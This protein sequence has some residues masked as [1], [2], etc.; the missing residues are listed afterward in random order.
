[1][2]IYN[3]KKRVQRNTL[4]TL[5]YQLQQPSIS[6]TSVK[7]DPQL[8]AWSHPPPLHLL[9]SPS[10]ETP[11]PITID[12]SIGRLVHTHKDTSFYWVSM[13]IVK[14]ILNGRQCSKL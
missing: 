12:L 13:S 3:I 4:K 2:C 10:P 8:A 7:Q 14:Y 1:M 11:E 9:R 6:A 5:S